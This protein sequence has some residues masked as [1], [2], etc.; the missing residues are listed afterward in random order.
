MADQQNAKTSS[1]AWQ[2]AI[3]T[4][5]KSVN[6]VANASMANDEFS[7]VMNQAMKLSLL[8]QQSLGSVMSVYLS[9][10]NIPTKAEV[11]ALGERLQSIEFRL[12]R[13]TSLLETLARE[14]RSAPSARVDGAA[15]PASSADPGAVHTASG[16]YADS[17]RPM[18][19]R[20]KRPPGKAT[21]KK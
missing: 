4:W 18:P 11:A 15:A 6:S 19:P 9:A 1:A 10:L 2:D 5:E 21:A 13:M 14:A 17:S 12:D 3:S 16:A 8:M 20:T 7:G